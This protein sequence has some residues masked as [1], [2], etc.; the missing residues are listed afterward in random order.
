MSRFHERLTTG[1]LPL[2]L[3]AA[4]I[5]GGALFSQ[6]ALSAT[7]YISEFAS[8]VSQVGTVTA[9]V[10]P[11]PSLADQTVAVGASSA[12][13]SAFNVSTHAVLLSC[14][15]ACSVLVGASPTAQ[16]TNFRIPANIV[17]VFA[18]LPGQ[19]IATIASP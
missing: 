1:L 16:T 6:G 3:A 19:K 7:L 12:Q 5:L 17:I 10:M 14:D 15:V 4:L 8:P 11:Q 18:V 2:A 13:S 9:Q